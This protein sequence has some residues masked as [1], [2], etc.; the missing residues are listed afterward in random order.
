[1]H[2]DSSVAMSASTT[3]EP[4]A[5]PVRRSSHCAKASASSSSQT[6]ESP[7]R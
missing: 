7:S 2:G 3:P 1:M 6:P 4:R 5:A